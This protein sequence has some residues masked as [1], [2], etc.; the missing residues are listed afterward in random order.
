MR[1]DEQRL[2]DILEAS[3]SLARI[4][5]RRTFDELT[6]DETLRYAVIRGCPLIRR[7]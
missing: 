6:S 7:K 3:D 2:R 4:I 5:E 1:R